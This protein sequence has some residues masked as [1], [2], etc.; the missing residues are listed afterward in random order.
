MT[1]L[2][3]DAGQSARYPIMLGV[4]AEGHG[5]SV[6]TASARIVNV[7]V[8]TALWAILPMCAAPDPAVCRHRSPG[9]ASVHGPESALFAVVSTRSAAEPGEAHERQ[10][11]QTRHDKRYPGAA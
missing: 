5:N 2:T 9:I 8:M 10:G 11:E 3:G 4:L 1:V 6:A 7:S